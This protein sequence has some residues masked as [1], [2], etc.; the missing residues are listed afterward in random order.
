[1]IGG[2]RAKRPRGGSADSPKS[3]GEV[4]VRREAA[5]GRDAVDRQLGRLQEPARVL[6]SPLDLGVLWSK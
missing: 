3:T 2:A 1:V 4:D 5:F 6:E